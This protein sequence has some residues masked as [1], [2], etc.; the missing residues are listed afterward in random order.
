MIIGMESAASSKPLN[1]N[2]IIKMINL[3]SVGILTII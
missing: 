1:K 2:N 3:R